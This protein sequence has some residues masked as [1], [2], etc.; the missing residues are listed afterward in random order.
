MHRKTIFII[1]FFCFLLARNTLALSHQIGVKSGDWVKYQAGGSIAEHENIVWVRIEVKSVDVQ[2]KTV[3][4][5]LT[6]HISNGSEF[7]ET[8]CFNLVT[9]RYIPEENYTIIPP[10]ILTNL[11]VGDVP[12]ESVPEKYTIQGD[13]MKTYCGVKRQV[14]YFHIDEWSDSTDPEHNILTAYWDKTTGFLLEY[15]ITMDSV[16]LKMTA[17]ETNLWSRDLFANHD[18]LLWAI[19]IITIACV[20][21]IT[22]YVLRKRKKR[23]QDHYISGS[24]TVYC[25][26]CG[27]PMHIEDNFC[28]KCGQKAERKHLP[29]AEEE[30]YKLYLQKLEEKHNAGEISEEIYQKLKNEYLE[31]LRKTN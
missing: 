23:T 13:I 6:S 28:P 3:T 16:S 14:L 12:Y 18:W 26:R 1:S 11:E 10:F 17:I 27:A 8:F 21:T 9:G 24:K 25:S 20:A 30:K 29:Q 7:S 22:I 31:K 4:F 5:D 15:E 19:V 2:E